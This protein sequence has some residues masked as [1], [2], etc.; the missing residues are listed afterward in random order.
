MESA[1][2]AGAGVTAATLLACS[3]GQE[4][5][6]A[7]TQGPAAKEP[8]RGGILI[9]GGGEGNTLDSDGRGLDPHIQSGLA[10]RGLRLI[11]QGLLAYNLRT[12]EVLPE[13]AQRWEQPSPTE[14]VFTLQ[15]G[16]KW[17]NKAPANG[18]LLTAEDVEFSLRRNMTTD[19]QFTASSLLANVDQLQAVDKGT[20]RIRT[21]EPNV[22]TLINLAADTL[23]VLAPEVVEKAGRFSTAESGVGTGAFV[24]Q[25]LEDNVGNRYVRNPDYWKPGLPYLDEVQT[26]HFRDSQPQ[27]AAF[28]SGK[29]HVLTIPGTE[30]KKYVQQQGSDF[31]PDWY[32]DESSSMSMANTRV[33]PLDD[34]RVVRALRLLID[35][36]EFLT[37]WT[38]VWFGRG[39][40]G[41]IFTTALQDTWDFTQD[42]YPQ[43]LEYKKVK[44]EAVREAMSL[45]NAAGFNAGN[46]LKFELA[47]SGANL[48]VAASQLLQAQWKRLSQGVVEVTVNPLD[49]AIQ[50]RVRNQGQFTYM[51]TGNSGS[52]V[53]PDS[54]LSEL[55]QTNGSKNFMKFSDPRLDALITRQRTMF[56]HQERKAVVKEAI[57]YTIDQGMTVLHA[58]RWFLNA[59]KPEVRDFAPEFNMSGRQYEGIWLDV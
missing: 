53:D 14:Y 55:Y 31:K 35:H 24:I 41:S 49:Q 48:Q 39:S 52:V 40:H 6:P 36:D 57:K 5:T 47:S 44:D 17:H 42:E 33:K 51:L 30:T 54:W 3:R 56:N 19:P 38:D 45:L 32:A 4:A 46:P 23:M 7:G 16:V 25:T 11:Y 2:L 43:F 20:I 59:T 9:R 10:A 58:N 37:A 27:W 29:L 34:M 28:L 12:F 13:I 18:R 22:A 8:K 15:P 1:A 50:N 26:P 21:K